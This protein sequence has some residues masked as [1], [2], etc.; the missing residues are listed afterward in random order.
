LI[1]ASGARP[2][3]HPHL[4]EKQAMKEVDKKDAPEVTGGYF[5]PLCTDPPGYPIPEADYPQY[6]SN[7]YG[8]ND[9]P[10]GEKQS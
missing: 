6:P 1:R 9:L 10:V 2:G 5:G 4:Q 7:P 8:E 3:R